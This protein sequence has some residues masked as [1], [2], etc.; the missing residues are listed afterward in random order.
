[1]CTLT[2]VTEVVADR[3]QVTDHERRL[4]VCWQR[5]RG[6]LDLKEKWCVILTNVLEVP[7][8]VEPRGSAPEQKVARLQ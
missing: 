6:D 1:M 3:L 7:P 8:P 5:A 4:V 2:R